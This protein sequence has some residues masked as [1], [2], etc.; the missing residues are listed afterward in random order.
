MHSQSIVLLINFCNK[1]IQTTTTNKNRSNNL[2]IN[3]AT[4]AFS[5]YYTTYQFCCS[6]TRTTQE[7][8]DSQDLK[9][10]SFTNSDVHNIINL[11]NYYSR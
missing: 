3:T 4:H 6:K 1:L 10:E 9:C 2:I 8:T 11:L 7:I 5:I